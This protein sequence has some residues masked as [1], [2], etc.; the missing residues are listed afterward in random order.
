MDYTANMLEEKIR[1]GAATLRTVA[2]LILPQLE[3]PCR[4]PVCPVQ[5]GAPRFI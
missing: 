3:D 5:K 1:I 4:E 2:L